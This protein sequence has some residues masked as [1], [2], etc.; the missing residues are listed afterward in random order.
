MF[1]HQLSLLSHSK[2]TCPQRMTIQQVAENIKNGEWPPGYQ[3]VLMVQG[4]YEGGIHQKDLTCLS[5]LSAAVFS[6]LD[7]DSMAKL[8]EEARDDPHTLML[9]TV[10]DSLVILYPYELDQGYELRLQCQFY[11]K[12]FLYG[13]DYYE[14]LLGAQSVKKGK[15]ASRCIPLARDGDA[16][17]NPMADPFLVWEIKEGCRRQTSRVKSREGLRERKENYREMYM[18][19]EEIEEWLSRHIELRHNLITRRREYRWLEDG[20]VEGSGAWLNFDD[21]TLNTLYRHISKV[22][23]VKRDVIDHLVGSDFV[24][25]FNPF[26]A[27]FDSLPSYDGDDYILSTA[28]G[29]SIEG[30]FDDWRIFV[31]CFRKWLVAMVASWLNPEVV[32]HMILVFIGKQGIY[33]TT[34]MNHLLPPELRSYFSTQMGI[35]R[36]DKDALL[37]MS[38]Y[39][40]ICCE[41]LDT[42]SRREM[43]EMKRAITLSYIDAR[44]AYGRYVEHRPHIASFCGTGNNEKFLNDPTG[45]R[46]WLAFKVEHIESPIRQPFNYKGIY[47]QAYYLYRNRF[48]Y[49]FSDNDTVAID[50]RNNRFKVA[51]IEKQLVYRYYRL[52]SGSDTGE[53][54]DTGTALQ[55]MSGN[56]AHK[57]HIEAL[58]QAF[59][60]LGFQSVECDGMHGY[61]AV[62]RMPEEINA[63]GRQMAHMIKTDTDSA[64]PF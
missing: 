13:N 31:E 11:R 5:Q 10:A 58:D 25:D 47:A 8:R 28:A 64:E 61:L 53:F 22:K 62:R 37:A 15:D 57:L 36:T 23:N 12:A 60:E 1:N 49:W 46:R 56:I 34:W 39:G 59:L 26:Q 55:Q 48:Q 30:D 16:Y 19:S 24:R 18:S 35:G 54:I 32:N 45:T 42:M 38:Q 6:H 9:F 33:K 51:N 20:A 29:V 17:Y 2:D 40:L 21:K 52:P 4:V 43:N 50:K 27:Y 14:Q 7:N 3:P 44:P 41:E 63:L